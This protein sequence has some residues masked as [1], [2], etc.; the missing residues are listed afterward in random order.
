[1]VEKVLFEVAFE[2]MKV[3]AEVVVTTADGVAPT[4]GGASPVGRNDPP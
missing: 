3:V 2:A 4:V 1:M